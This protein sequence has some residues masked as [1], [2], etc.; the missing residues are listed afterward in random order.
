[1]VPHSINKV[2][3]Q[4][5]NYYDAWGA[6]YDNEGIVTVWQLNSA[7]G[8]YKAESVEKAEKAADRINLSLKGSN[9]A[10]VFYNTIE[11]LTVA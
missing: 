4:M 9:L 10:A 7:A 2:I 1:M 8:I 5:A 3:K 11:S 6:T